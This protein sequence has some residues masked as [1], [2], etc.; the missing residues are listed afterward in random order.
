MVTKRSTFNIFKNNN[1]LINGKNNF[2][3]PNGVNKDFF[4]PIP[5]EQA[6]NKL[7]MDCSKI[8][9]LFVSSNFIRK[10]KRYDRFKNVISILQENYK[11]KCIEEIILT[12][13]S[14]ELTPYY[15]NMADVHLLTSDFEGS[16]NSVKECMACN[17]SVVSTNV[18]NVRE[19]LQGTKDSFVG[20]RVN[21]VELAKLVIKAIDSKEKNGRDQ[22]IKLELD[23]KSVAIKLI[24][25]YK[26]IPTTK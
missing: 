8:Y 2:Y 13:T 24:N 17:T 3:L 11:N 26:K 14:R 21:E 9:I 22:I 16:P 6:C 19:L 15:Y 18:G 23:S 10:Q 25:I 12:N 4:R 1:H 20:E 7:G 5:K